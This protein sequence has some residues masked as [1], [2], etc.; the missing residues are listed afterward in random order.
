M[1]YENEDDPLLR[2]PS[3]YL[4]ILQEPRQGSFGGSPAQRFEVLPS[5]TLRAVWGGW[6]KLSPVKELVGLTTSQAA[7]N[8]S[9]LGSSVP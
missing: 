2:I 1:V 3:T 5:G 8:I 9:Q 6:E 7:G 4:M